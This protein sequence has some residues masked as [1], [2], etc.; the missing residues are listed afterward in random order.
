MSHLIIGYGPA[1]SGK[2]TTARAWRSEGE[3]RTIVEAEDLSPMALTVAID[4]LDHGDVW[5]NIPLSEGAEVSFDLSHTEHTVELRRFSHRK[6]LDIPAE[7]ARMAQ[8]R[9]EIDALK[10]VAA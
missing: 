1:S 10:E 8:L 7:R 4:G 6:P 3:S 5:L 2:T 9:Q